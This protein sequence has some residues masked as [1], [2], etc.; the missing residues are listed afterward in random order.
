M[1]SGDL[2]SDPSLTSLFWLDARQLALLED[3]KH[4]LVLKILVAEIE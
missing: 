2:I 4:S 3:H 1:P